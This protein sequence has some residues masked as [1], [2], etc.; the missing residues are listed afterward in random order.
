MDNGECI[1]GSLYW[2]TYNGGC[3]EIYSTV[4]QSQWALDLYYSQ[5]ESTGSGTIV[6]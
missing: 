2:I 6:Q 4:D 1:I 5:P 3:I